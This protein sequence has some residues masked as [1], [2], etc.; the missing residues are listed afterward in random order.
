MVT[1]LLANYY[2]IDKRRSEDDCGHISD[3]EKRQK[4]CGEHTFIALFGQILY[5]VQTGKVS[6]CDFLAS[7]R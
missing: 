4:N 1:S 7:S 5:K 6:G 2:Q 3:I